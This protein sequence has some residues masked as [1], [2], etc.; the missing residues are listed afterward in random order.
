M[1]WRAAP[2]DPGR[3]REAHRRRTGLGA[4]GPGGIVGL[5]VIEDHPGFALLDN[6]A[7]K[8]STQG[9]GLGRRLLGF[10]ED[11]AR[12]RG[13]GELRLYTNARMVENIAM[14]RHLG[15]VEIG[16]VE[17]QGFGRVSMAKRL[18]EESGREE[19]AKTSS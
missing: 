16:R 4:R 14:H 3:L 2:G 1:P 8:P 19:R 12:R 9:Q 18:T 15:F 11:E 5:V 17:E 13:H 6:V 10:V 7:V